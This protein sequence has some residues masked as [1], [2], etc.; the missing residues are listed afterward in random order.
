MI[1][2]IQRVEVEIEGLSPLLMNSPKSMLE[3]K[4]STTKRTSAYN[5]EEEA[6]KVAYRND[7][8]KLYVPAT[9]IKGTM[10]GAAAY[11][12]A[13]KFTLRPLIASAVRVVGT[14]IIL[15]KQKYEIDLRTVV[16][17]RARVVKA[18]PVIKEWKLNFELDI[19][20]SSIADIDIVKSNLEEAG[21]RV[22][23]LDFR[24]Q[25]L[26]EFGMFK[27]SKWKLK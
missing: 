3:P 22:G 17:Q 27:I 18:R 7:D 6:E 4:A 12:K 1:N 15:N 24:P 2:T 10:I 19:D 16:I 14:E 21:S 13:G 11:K 25:K 8:G 26:G 9:A 23:I 5:Q 20:T